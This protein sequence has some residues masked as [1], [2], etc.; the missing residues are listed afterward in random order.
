MSQHSVTVTW[1]G[2]A[3][4]SDDADFT[5]FVQHMVKSQAHVSI[6]AHITVTTDQQ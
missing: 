3:T 1:D 2:P 5:D 6:G 4:F